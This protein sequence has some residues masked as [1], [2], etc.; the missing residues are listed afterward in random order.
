LVVPEAQALNSEQLCERDGYAGVKG[1]VVKELV[2][3]PSAEEVEDDL[4]RA[5]EPRLLDLIEQRPELMELLTYRIEAS[6]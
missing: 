2:D 1:E 6:A 3:S 4:I 5:L